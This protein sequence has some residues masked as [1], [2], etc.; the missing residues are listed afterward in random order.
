MAA[1]RF[2]AGGHEYTRASAADRCRQIAGEIT[3]EDHRFL[4]D[5]ILRHPSAT[6]KIGCGI[7][8]FNLAGENPVRLDLERDDGSTIDFSWC[9]CISAKERSHAQKC[10]T[11]MR[12]AIRDQRDAKRAWLFSHGIVRCA[13]TGQLLTPA[14]CHMDHK[15]PFSRLAAQFARE[16]GGW[17][18]IV[19]RDH[20][21]WLGQLM[22]DPG[23]SQRWQS[24][25]A[26]HAV[27]QPVLATVNLSK[28]PRDA[29]TDHVL[30]R[31]GG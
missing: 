24:F 8:R 10:R 28:G 13:I 31:F 5:L 2:T 12:V 7:R 6:E 20:N 27:L 17:Q 21:G 3:V 26:R 25:H 4:A 14:N 16:E 11:A 15:T 23:Q 1:E 29:A 22:A 18:R 30:S 19:V 9:Q